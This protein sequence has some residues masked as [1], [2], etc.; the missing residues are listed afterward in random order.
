MDDR[1]YERVRG[2]FIALCVAHA[3]AFKKLGRQQNAGAEFDQLV[4]TGKFSKIAVAHDHLFAQT[5]VVRIRRGNR[6]RVLGEYLIDISRSTF[7]AFNLTNQLAGKNGPHIG[8]D[9][10][11][12]MPEGAIEI[13]GLISDGQ[14]AD[15]LLIVEA[16]L[17]I[18][19]L[20]TPYQDAQIDLWPEEEPKAEATDA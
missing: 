1:S 12:C 19:G 14:L 5:R 15:A 18:H 17:W 4:R 2:E 7:L 13:R 20:G 16:A 11:F 9:G 3:P 8:A 6:M 10:S